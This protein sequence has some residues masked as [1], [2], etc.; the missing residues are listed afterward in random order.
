MGGHESLKYWTSIFTNIEKS[1]YEW[2]SNNTI[3]DIGDYELLLLADW[4]AEI[5]LVILVSHCCVDN[6]GLLH[7]KTV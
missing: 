7:T 5:W 3:K 6:L 2:N 1:L 4:L